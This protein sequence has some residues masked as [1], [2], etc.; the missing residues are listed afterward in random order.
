MKVSV[1]RKYGKGDIIKSEN[2][3]YLDVGSGVIPVYE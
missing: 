1:I 3:L 2:K